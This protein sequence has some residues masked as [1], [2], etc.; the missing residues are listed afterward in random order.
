MYEAF[1]GLRGRP[2]D[3]TPDPRFLFLTACHRE[4]LSLLQYV[5]SG[6]TGLGLLLGE[7]GTGKT[8]LLRAALLELAGGGGR[9]LTLDNP[10]LTRGEL[11]EFLA[12]GFGLAGGGS[13]TR[14]LHELALWV[15]E[16]ARAGGAT[17]LVVDEAQS[18]SGELLEEV[19]L[20]ANLQHSAERPLSIVLAGQPELAARLNEP[21]LRQLKQRIAFRGRLLPLTL[22]ETADYVA[23][24]LQVVGG[25]AAQTFT[26]AAVQAVFAHAG[27]IPRTISVVCE[28]ALVCGYA[29]QA[30]PIGEDIVAEVCRDLDIAC[31]PGALPPAGPASAPAST[32]TPTFT[33]AP[34]SAAAPTP[35][36]E[37]APE[38]RPGPP[39]VREAA[40]GPSAPRRVLDRLAFWSRRDPAP[41]RF[42]TEYFTVSGRQGML[43]TPVPHAPRARLSAPRP[44][45]T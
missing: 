38:P 14:V 35:E 39:R 12:G 8:T 11:F 17:A 45:R 13:K 7:A 29:L 31:S 4:A 44:E 5:L 23:C 6:R 40:P 16:R 9:V 41:R 3:L 28:S 32:P 42:Q 33:P 1:Y 22:Q 37:A 21:E 20:L 27:G 15:A 30:R 26:R 10:T 19:R 43:L 34:A 18:L 36:A 24:R 2:F 25:D